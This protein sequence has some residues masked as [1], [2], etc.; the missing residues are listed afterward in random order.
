VAT[1]HGGNLRELAQ[2]AGLDREQILDFSAS[3]NPLG[4][5]DVLRAV[6]SRGIGRLVHYPDPDSTELVDALAERHG[7]AREQIV[8]GNGSSELFFALTRAI[9]FRRALIPVPSYI[10]YATAVEAAGRDVCILNLEESADFAV[11]WPALEA[12]LRG[13]EIVML[14]QP[15]NPTGRAFDPDALRA[16]ASRHPTTT[17][18]VDEAFADFIDG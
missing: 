9:P 4:P 13:D 5:P 16:A 14:G 8:A 6:L 12:A 17:F 15:N 7:A 1:G 2:R 3:I 18:V 11:D 10:D